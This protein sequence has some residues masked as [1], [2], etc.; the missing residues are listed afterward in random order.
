[1]FGVVQRKFLN[2]HRALFSEQWTINYKIIRRCRY[3][4]LDFKVCF[5]FVIE[6]VC[7]LQ[8]YSLSWLAN[9]K[10]SSDYCSR[11]RPMSCN[12]P[13]PILWW[14]LIRSLETFLSVYF[15]PND[16]PQVERGDRQIHLCVTIYGWVSVSFVRP[17]V[18]NGTKRL[19]HREPVTIL[20]LSFVW[21]Q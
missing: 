15:T 13:G 10:A 11:R 5:L 16:W 4:S 14:P 18:H 8:V 20:A 17:R 3:G 1:M 2:Y 12:C 9:I 21:Q 7:G 6:F 19:S